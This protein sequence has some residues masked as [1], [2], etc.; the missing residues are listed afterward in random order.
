MTCNLNGVVYDL[1]MEKNQH[2]QN[3]KKEALKTSFENMSYH[4]I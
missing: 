3:C 4:N 2:R 1:M